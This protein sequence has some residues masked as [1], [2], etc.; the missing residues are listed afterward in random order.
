MKQITKTELTDL[1]NEKLRENEE[2]SECSINSINELLELN[3]F[4]SNWSV[5]FIQSGGTPKEVFMSIAVNIV[6]N[7]Q[8]QFK[9]AP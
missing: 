2:T 5:S 1:I 4:G 3:E 9:L 8:R 7:L 6:E